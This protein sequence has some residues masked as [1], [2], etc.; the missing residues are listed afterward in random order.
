MNPPCKSYREA[1]AAHALQAVADGLGTDRDHAERGGVPRERGRLDRG[2]VGLRERPL[3]D[4]VVQGACPL[5]VARVVELLEPEHG[6]RFGL[7]RVEVAQGRVA[8]AEV[9]DGQAHA[10]CAQ[11]IERRLR[12]HRGLH[13][14]RFGDLQ[15]QAVRGEAAAAQALGHEVHVAIGDLA[16]FET[17]AIANYEQ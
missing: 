2:D 13:Q 11:L 7:V 9:V 14:R 12:R 15:A 3:D 10:Q 5:E 16:Q 8:G 6:C 17:V 4:R 1:G